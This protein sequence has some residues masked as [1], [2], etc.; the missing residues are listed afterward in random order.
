MKTKQIEDGIVDLFNSRNS[1]RGI[2]LKYNQT[3]GDMRQLLKD[4]IPTK[5]A[6]GV[7]FKNS[8][9]YWYLPF[10]EHPLMGEFDDVLVLSK[11]EFNSYGWDV[12]N[13]EI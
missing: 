13:D 7:R 1:Q 3:Y 6:G 5:G 4:N 9:K 12:P 11:E 10:V 8:I 2:T